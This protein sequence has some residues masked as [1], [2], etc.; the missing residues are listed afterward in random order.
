MALPPFQPIPISNPPASDLVSPPLSGEDPGAENVGLRKMCE[1][2]RSSLDA[3]ANN[4][5]AFQADVKRLMDPSTS[6]LAAEEKAAENFGGLGP[7]SLGNQF[8]TLYHSTNPKGLFQY[9][10]K[11][12]VAQHPDQTYEDWLDYVTAD[13]MPISDALD[14]DS[15]INVRTNGAG[16]SYVD[17][18]WW[19]PDSRLEISTQPTGS[20]QADNNFFTICQ[21]VSLA[22]EWY[23]HGLAS[24]TLDAAKNDI[25]GIRPTVFDGMN[26][27]WIQREA[28]QEART[29]GDAVETLVVQALQISD[30]A[31]ITYN[32]PNSAILE[33]LSSAV[34][35]DD[36]AGDL[37]KVVAASPKAESLRVENWQMIIV[38]QCRAARAA[39]DEYFGSSC[40]FPPEDS[41]K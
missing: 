12:W 20:S 23:P 14:Q 41:N 25:E 33:A 27:V 2:D 22:P 31:A 11:Y 17:P 28:S 40:A 16:G 6:L 36:Y 35:V 37:S 10:S 24:M 3:V 7:S 26:P 34:G 19:S 8:D 32:V 18:G 29:G 9:N 39:A 13:A 1:I 15:Y 30:L 4:R 38:E 5:K 21:L